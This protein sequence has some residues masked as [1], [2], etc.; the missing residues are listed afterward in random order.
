MNSAGRYLLSNSAEAAE[1][2]LEALAEIFDPI[3]VA[4][5]DRL[6]IRAGWRCWEIGAG[7]MSIPSY[8]ASVVGDSGYVLATDIDT[9]RMSDSPA[10]NIS[11][12]AH[13]VANDPLPTGSFDLVHARLVLVHLSSRNEVLKRI[14]SV[15]KPGGWLLVEDAD[16]KLQPLSCID[17]STDKANLANRIR[18]GFR[19][20]LE[21]RGA[22]LAFGRR[23][24]AMFREAGLS[25][26]GADAYFPVSMEPCERLEM[27]TIFMIRNELIANKIATEDEV[28]VHL[29]N[30][31][32]GSLDL[33]QPPLI[34]C[35]GRKSP[36]TR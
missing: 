27:A 35:W 21:S 18:N 2:R 10:G 25:E 31:V 3:T 29:S 19:D 14:I 36:A 15:L 12:Q 20:L 30:V 16:P 6:G 26:V 34:S 17:E 1:A 7:S 13:D 23:L 28:E 22:D 32:E 5:A 9:S 24:P 4:H 8:L 33:A 11:V